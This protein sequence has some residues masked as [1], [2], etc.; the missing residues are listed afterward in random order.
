MWAHWGRSEQ[1]EER[2]YQVHVT[3][4]TYLHVASGGKCSSWLT[5]RESLLFCS[6]KFCQ[7]SI[8]SCSCEEGT[9]LSPLFRTASDEKLGRGLGVRLLSIF[10]RLTPYLGESGW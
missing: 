1:Q 7:L 4:H 10:V 3:Y 2:R 8:T 5:I 6:G 9:R